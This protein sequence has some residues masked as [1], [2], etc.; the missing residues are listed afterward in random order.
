[1]KRRHFTRPFKAGIVA[2]ME[3]ESIPDLVEELQV[4]PSL[5]YCW[6]RAHQAKD[7][8]SCSIRIDVPKSVLHE[9]ITNYLNTKIAA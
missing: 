6:Q 2:R 1:M 9:F 7:E 5:L 3:K 8:E 4:S